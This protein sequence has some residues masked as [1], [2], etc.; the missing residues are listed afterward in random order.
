MKLAGRGRRFALLTH[1]RIV[2]E[3]GLPSERPS[4]RLCGE[5]RLAIIMAKPSGISGFFRVGM[6]AQGP[7]V[8]GFAYYACQYAQ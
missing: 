5:L 6:N 3:L 8:G 1:H 4:C 7:V 2:P